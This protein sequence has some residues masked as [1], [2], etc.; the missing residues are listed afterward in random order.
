MSEQGPMTPE[1]AARD[2]E[3]TVHH[4][5]RRKKQA[6]A[7]ARMQI[8]L[9]AMI[10]VTF[11]LLI[12]FV[13]T[14]NFMLDEGVLIAR[15]PQGT[16]RAQEQSLEP[17]P[18]PLVIE[19]APRGVRDVSIHVDGEP[20]ISTFTDLAQQLQAWQVSERNPAGL[21]KPD[22]PVIIRPL[23]EVRWAHVVNTFNAAI[24]ARYTNVA[25]AESQ[26]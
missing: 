15:M 26:D 19:L 22:N 3:P 8:N 5:A 23:G 2:D 18:Q 10:D 4:V 20:G 9:T 1:R 14:A 25:F 11:Q 24:K 12:Y 7:P 13:V 17:P 6:L 16:G 21:Y